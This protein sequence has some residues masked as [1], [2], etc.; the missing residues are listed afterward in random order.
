MASPAVAWH[1]AGPPGQ[2]L[3]LPAT[4]SS[5]LANG[6]SRGVSRWTGARGQGVTDPTGRHTRMRRTDRVAVALIT[7]TAA[8]A[9]ATGLART[10]S[11]GPYHHPPLPQNP[12]LGQRVSE[13]DRLDGSLRRAMESRLPSLP[14]LGTRAR[15]VRR[16]L[17]RH[18]ECSGA[19]G[20][21]RPPRRRR[22]PRP[23]DRGCPPA[24]CRRRRPPPRRR[25][26]P[27]P[28]TP[29][30][31]APVAAPPEPAPP[32]PVQAPAAGSG[33]P[34]RSSGRHRGWGRDGGPGPRRG[35]RA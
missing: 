3:S 6:V 8:L 20:P 17:R 5:V 13:L 18:G 26:A 1:P 19:S 14:S 29:A 35:G 12:L 9:G 24:W 7:G 31:A 33:R 22:G 32:A 30:P 21:A 10:T 11:L 27:P 4:R 34:S 25:G 23:L 15:R 2:V 28:V 16:R